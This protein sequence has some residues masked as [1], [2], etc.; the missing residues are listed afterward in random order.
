[1]DDIPEPRVSPG[2]IVEDR[3][4]GCWMRHPDGW[5]NELDIVSGLGDVPG[6]AVQDWSYVQRWF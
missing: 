5:V 1:M 2:A 6:F 3:E 4:G